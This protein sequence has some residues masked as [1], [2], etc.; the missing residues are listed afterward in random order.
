MIAF[1][2]RSDYNGEAGFDYTIS[3]GRGGT[4]IGRVSLTI[5]PQ[6][7]A[8]VLRPDILEAHEDRV[9]IIL[10][11]ELF[12]NDFDPEGDVPM[13]AGA[14]VLGLVALT[15]E[16]READ[17]SL[18][19]DVARL[20]PGTVISAWLADG[21]DLP[22]G[23][24]FDP[25]T[26]RLSGSLPE[27]VALPLDIAVSFTLP[28]ALG[29][30]VL[31]RQLSLTVADLPALAEGVALQTGLALQDMTAKGLMADWGMA[32]TEGPGQWKASLPT[33]RDMPAWVQFDPET[34]AVSVDPALVPEGAGPVTLRLTW[35]PDLP[36]LAANLY[37]T[38]TGGFALDLVIDPLTGLSAEAAQ[39]LS[40]QAF[41]RAQGLFGLPLGDLPTVTASLEN[42]QPLPSWLSLDPVSLR[43]SGTPPEGD[44]VGNPMVRLDL[45]GLSLV[46]EVLV[47]SIFRAETAE[48]FDLRIVDDYVLVLPPEDYD[49]LF[50]FTYTAQDQIGAISQ[51]P[52]LV[53]VNLLPT[54]E[55]PDAGDDTVRIDSSGV[56]ELAVT[57]L[58]ANDS[59]RDGDA[60]WITG[61]TAPEH[62]TLEV[63]TAQVQ[64]T[65]AEAGLDPAEGAQWSGQLASGDPLPNWISVDALSG[66]IRFEVP[67]HF[68]GAVD[69]A[70]TRVVE[71]I[72]ET[73]TLHQVLNG[74]VGAVL[75]Y[76]LP[77]QYIGSETIR[78][79]VTDGAA[80]VDEGAVEADLTFL[81]NS[82]PV[83][84]EDRFVTLEDTALEVSVA[85][86]LANDR[87]ADGDALTLLSVGGAQ[88]GTV[89][90]SGGTVTFVPD[91]N[92]DGAAQFTYTISDG[93]GGVV[94]GVAQVT[95]TST[96][97]APQPG[98]DSYAGTED[99]PIQ[100]RIADLLANDT[101]PDGDTLTFLGFDTV[102]GL[103]VAEMP[104]GDWQIMPDVNLN[105]P[106]VLTYRISD[107][108][109][110]R[111]GTIELTLAPVNDAPTLFADAAVET[112]MGQPVTISLAALL[113][114]DRDPEGDSFTVIE[115]YD[116]DNGT[117]VQ[118]GDS[119]T[120]TPRAGYAGN[121]GFRYVVEDAH[122]ARVTGYAAVQILPEA[123]LPVAVSDLLTMQEDGTLII[124]PAVL[125]AN[126]NANGGGDLVFLG[127]QGVGVT[128][129]AD[130]RYSYTPPLNENGERVLTYRITNAS[131][132]AVTGSLT[133]DIAPLPDAPVAQ[134]DVLH[135]IED[136]ELVIDV[137]TLLANDH[138]PDLNGFWISSVT[139]LEGVSVTLTEA[140][141]IRIQ[142]EANRTA[143]GRFS[144]T[145]TDSSGLTSETVV[146]V[147]I[148]PVNDLPVLAAPLSDRHATEETA[149][150]I[151]LQTSLFSDPDGDALTY[152]LTLADGSAL[153]AW[154]I[155]NPLTQTI[156][157]TPP[158][159]LSGDVMLRL[160]ASDGLASISDD[161]ALRIANTADP[162]RLVRALADVAVDGTGAPITLGRPFSFAADLGAF[163]DPDGTPLTYTARLADLQWHA[164]H[165]HAAR[166]CPR[167]A[168]HPADGIGWR[169]QRGGCLPPDPCA[170]RADHRHGWQ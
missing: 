13:I 148:T 32:T 30:A 124:D 29:G 112:R 150:H 147:N 110:T 4:D 10:P 114:N 16:G 120:F 141:Q 116:P 80:T 115:V 97:R 26:L 105:G 68:R 101:D 133:I 23:L 142:P 2:P 165:R 22:A 45:G 118:A 76:T 99:S 85:T 56:V 58:L 89:T 95:V 91:H 167:G 143:P 113:A 131:G 57:D 122:G 103:S 75:R 132:I 156:S 39:I 106:M 31:Q 12:G 21:S 146:M 18:A 53:V 64:V 36:D 168:G 94:T 44:Y 5:L 41:F 126:D 96:N 137:T 84:G 152:T 111:T 82:T 71:G 72:R 34:L 155:F 1:I 90:L 25:V 125:M 117:L 86:L 52:G 109:I 70:L 43:F 9:R 104:N 50:A 170:T 140:G 59:D 123:A 6:N 33:G 108:R 161:F 48:G 35:Q 63:L 121:A 54:R 66:A 37:S 134:A 166:Q 15:E 20:A 169:V 65:A 98:L 46:T 128:P 149:F 11:G 138:D 163:V 83:A 77:E 136:T 61:F 88:H 87:D 55:R 60:I 160:T 8:P 92:Y 93:R 28:A 79:T 102:Q 144:Y 40:D 162:V 19:F 47:D 74:N 81:A 158:Q 130:G 164:I 7:D 127:L 67:L 3:D 49:G 42:G 100:I 154:L 24:V 17:T 153:P 69:V 107:G 129:L 14:T 78:Y 62:G 151:V 135:L 139:A 51:P 38:A 73:V 27:G 145:L 159:D 157:G 119:V